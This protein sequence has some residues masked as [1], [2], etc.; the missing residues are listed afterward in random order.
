MNYEQDAQNTFS[1]CKLRMCMVFGKKKNKLK[2]LKIWLEN[3][4][5]LEKEKIGDINQLNEIKKII[6]NE[7]VPSDSQMRY[8]RKLDDELTRKQRPL[9]TMS[10]TIE[11]QKI[12]E[13][14]GIVSGHSV[15]GMNIFS[16]WFAGI[17]DII[18]GRSESYEQYFIDAREKAIDDMVFEAEELDA[19]AIISIKIDYSSIEAKNTRMLMVSANGTAVKSV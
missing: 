13:Y 4:E 9:L 19:T 14:L 18:G 16:D 10:H 15:L 1:I 8:L 17:R 5:E 11:G 6:E 2:D 3:I 12:T 7:Q